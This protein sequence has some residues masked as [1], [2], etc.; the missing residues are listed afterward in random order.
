MLMPSTEKA[1]R[2]TTGW[3][4]QRLLED[5]PNF[6]EY[7]SS[8]SQQKKNLSMASKKKGAPHTIVVTSAGLRAADI[9]RLS[10]V[11]DFPF[12]HTY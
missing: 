3:E 8:K 6:L 12:S 4:K 7:Y 5:L 1:F 11:S 10:L 2:D 9:T